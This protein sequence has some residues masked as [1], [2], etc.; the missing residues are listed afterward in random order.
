MRDA[1]RRGFLKVMGLAVPAGVG[2]SALAGA[3]MAELFSE[4]RDRSEDGPEFSER[5]IEQLQH[6]IEIMENERI[7]GRILDGY[8]VCS[9]YRGPSGYSQPAQVTLQFR[10]KA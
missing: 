10:M 8:R 1:T 5:E 6:I 4:E 7:D 3:A 2:S 9:S